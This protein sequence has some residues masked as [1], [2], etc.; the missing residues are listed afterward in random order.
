MRQHFWAL[1]QIRQK[2]TDV[3]RRA[4]RILPGMRVRIQSEDQRHPGV[5]SLLPYRAHH[6]RR[7]EP[8]RV[9]VERRQEHP[10][11]LGAAKARERHEEGADVAV[12]HGHVARKRRLEAH[13]LGSGRLGQAAF[14]HEQQRVLVAHVVHRA[15][16]EEREPAA[17][18]VMCPESLDERA[19][20][21][22][23]KDYVGVVVCTLVRQD[24]DDVG[25]LVDDERAAQLQLQS[26]PIYA[27]SGRAG[28]HDV[29]Q[30]C[31]K[32]RLA[33]HLQGQRY[34]LLFL[35][36]GGVLCPLD[37]LQKSANFLRLNLALFVLD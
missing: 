6:G 17:E 8:R 27:G 13:L 12:R 18:A 23:Q 36:H 5:S 4:F 1:L 20:N 32:N 29:H 2:C 33:Q 24:L 10:A 19:R 22:L 26:V 28:V 25:L 7:R 31:V 11:G 30:H 35:G 14:R 21:L 9:A 3:L 37:W 34:G 15:R 16:G